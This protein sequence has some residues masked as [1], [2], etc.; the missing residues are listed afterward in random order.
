MTTATTAKK[1]RAHLE[2]LQQAYTALEAKI[3]PLKDERDAFIAKHRAVYDTERAMANTIKA[4]QEEAV[5]IAMELREL[6][7]L[8]SGTSG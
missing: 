3:N 1:I 6:R 4:L 7:K 2:Q 8:L 5:P